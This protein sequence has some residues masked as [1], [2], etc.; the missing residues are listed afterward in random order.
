MTLVEFAIFKRSEL[1]LEISERAD[2]LLEI[3]KYDFQINLR[4]K[5]RLKTKYIDPKKPKQCSGTLFGSSWTF[6]KKGLDDFRDGV[7]PDVSSEEMILRVSMIMVTDKAVFYFHF[8]D[9]RKYCSL[10]NT[11]WHECCKFV[12]SFWDVKVLVIKCLPIFT[13]RH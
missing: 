6:I 10:Y 1:Q 4:Y 9:L 2:L 11:N 12:N 5:E 7:P 8:E 3:R 13:L